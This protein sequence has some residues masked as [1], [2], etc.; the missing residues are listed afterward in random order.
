MATLEEAEIDR[1][2]A[3][4]DRVRAVF[5]KVVFFVGS[6]SLP[7]DLLKEVSEVI[8]LSKIG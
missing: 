8:D 3:E 6:M 2:N 1:L 7:E 4:L 5:G